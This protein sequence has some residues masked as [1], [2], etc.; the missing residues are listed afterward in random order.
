MSRSRV[1]PLLLTVL[2]LESAAH[3][4]WAQSTAVS[5]PPPEVIACYGPQVVGRLPGQPKGKSYVSGI[6]FAPQVGGVNNWDLLGA[7]YRAFVRDKYGAD[8]EPRCT[9][10]PSEA[11]AEKWLRSVASGPDASTRLVGNPT[12]VMTAWTWKPTVTDTAAPPPQVKKPGAL[13]H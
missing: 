2:M 8:F 4:S 3:A 1:L 5:G 13:E 11:D 10:F 12:V 6:S 9:T 7:A